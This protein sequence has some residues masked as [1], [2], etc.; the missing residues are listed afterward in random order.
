MVHCQIVFKWQWAHLIWSC[1]QSLG[2]TNINLICIIPW[3][4]IYL[5]CIDCVTSSMFVLIAPGRQRRDCGAFSRFWGVCSVPGYW[6]TRQALLNCYHY[7]AFH[8]CHWSMLS[9]CY[10]AC[11]RS[12][13]WLPCRHILPY[14]TSYHLLFV[15]V[16]AL[17]VVVACFDLLL[18]VCLY[19]FFTC[20]VW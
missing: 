4:C 3:L 20:L 16:L 7:I 17:R 14:P 11:V 10:D 13:T 1:M 19:F 12:Y 18:Q 2:N 6:A 8:S 5:P 9:L 15:Y